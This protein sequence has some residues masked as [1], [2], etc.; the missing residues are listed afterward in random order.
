MSAVHEVT[1]LIEGGGPEGTTLAL[2]L[3]SR[4]IASMVVEE[5][6][7]MMAHRVRANV[8]CASVPLATGGPRL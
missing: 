8:W 2:D 3:A 6:F 1:A 4:C 5:Q 7:A